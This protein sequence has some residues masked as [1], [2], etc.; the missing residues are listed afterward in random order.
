MNNY[1][2]TSESVS[3]GHPDK[4]CDQIS[5]ALVDAVL[6]AEKEA[7]LRGD[8]DKDSLFSRAAFETMIKGELN[9]DRSIKLQSVI[10]AGEGRMVEGA[11]INAEEIARDVINKVG[12][13]NPA[14]GFDGNTCEVIDYLGRQSGDIAKG[15]DKEIGAGDQGL[16]FGYACN[17]TDSHMPLPIHLAHQLIRRH[18]ELRRS[19]RFPWLMPDAKSQVSVRYQNGQPVGVETVVFSTQHSADITLEEVRAQVAQEIIAP[20][21]GGETKNHINP[22]GEFVIGGPAADCGL[23]GRK[24]IVDTYGGAAPHGG[25]AFSGKDPT[26]VDRSAAYALRHIAKNI[27]AARVA[28]KCL[29][30]AAYAIGEPQPVSIMVD[31][32]GTG[33]DEK[34]SAFVQQEIDLTPKGIITRLNLW[35]PIYAISAAYGHFGRTAENGD[36]PWEALDLVDT[37]RN[38]FA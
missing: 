5:D 17:E 7:I 26:K 35:R 9:D 20:I 23:T 27:V 21:I 8:I 18:D 33:D 10:L 22:A 11:N 6:L 32:K 4:I 16:M 14:F 2:F 29:I 25:G 31:T 12:Y 28:E 24:I 3:A 15:V 13:D 30:Q 37:I 1:L 38:K 36:F 34:L 19:G